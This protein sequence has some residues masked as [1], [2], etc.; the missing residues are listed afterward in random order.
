MTARTVVHQRRVTRGERSGVKEF[1]VSASLKSDDDS[2]A[3][4]DGEEADEEARHPPKMDLA[5]VAEIALVL[6]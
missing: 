3:D 2:E 1:F 4:G 6:S 5:E